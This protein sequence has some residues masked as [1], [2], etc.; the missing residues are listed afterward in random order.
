MDPRSGSPYSAF[1]D[2]LENVSPG[3]HTLSLRL[4]IKL[5]PPDPEASD[6]YTN[7]GNIDYHEPGWYPPIHEKTLE[8]SKSFEVL[9]EEPPDYITRVYDAAFDQEMPRH[10]SLSL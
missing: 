4:R 2:K 7:Y 1:P 3:Q 10:I 6:G 9:T 8:L 5:F